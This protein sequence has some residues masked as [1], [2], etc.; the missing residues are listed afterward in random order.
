MRG[1]VKVLVA[2]G[3]LMAGLGASAPAAAAT[4]PPTL[5]A[6]GFACSNGV[7]QIGPGNLGVAFAAAL[8]ATGEQCG[9]EGGTTPEVT[10]VVSGSLP[11]G[12]QFGLPGEEAQIT[13]TP[14]QA[15]TY[16]FA[17]QLAN[18]NDD[19]GQIC[20]PTGTQQLAITIGTGRSDRLILYSAFLNLECGSSEP[21]MQLEDSDANSGATYTVT[22]T[23]TGM[24]IDTFTGNESGISVLHRFA[25]PSGTFPHGPHP[26]SVTVT[27]T[28]GGSATIPVRQASGC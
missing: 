18:V 1:S 6:S 27:D 25:V 23:S 3:A 19:S 17:V 4:S 28:L 16:S 10:K 5:E 24:R 12:L 21:V 9:T 11:P 15:G 14:T 13:G 2:C 7:C 26:G 22:Q 20:G 8:I